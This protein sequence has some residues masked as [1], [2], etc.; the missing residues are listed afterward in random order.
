MIDYAGIALFL[1]GNK[2][3]ENNVVLS[4]GMR[5]EYTIARRKGL[6]VIP[7]GATGYMAE[8]LWA[9]LN[10]EIQGDPKVS[11]QMKGL[12]EKIGDKATTTDDLIDAVL[13]ILDAR[14]V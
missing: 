14:N 6:F 3:H 5:E 9:E 11:E 2:L 13:N 4:N 12:F 8:E 7:I 10:N 1:F